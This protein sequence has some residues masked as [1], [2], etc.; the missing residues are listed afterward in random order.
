MF[1]KHVFVDKR[2]QIPTSY[3][4]QCFLYLNRADSCKWI[5]NSLRRNSAN[6]EIVL[7]K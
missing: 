3:K 7:K 5:F 6:F 2:L 4:K 1:K